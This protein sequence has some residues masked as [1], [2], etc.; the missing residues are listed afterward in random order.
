MLPA[1]MNVPVMA[2]VLA[3]LTANPVVAR[4]EW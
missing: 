4:G 2:Q 1:E 3:I